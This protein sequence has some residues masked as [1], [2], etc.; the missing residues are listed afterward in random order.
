MVLAK[1][2]LKTLVKGINTAKLVKTIIK[3]NN[4]PITRYYLK[5][6]RDEGLTKASLLLKVGNAR[7][8]RDLY[9]LGV[10]YEA[11]IYHA[12]P[13]LADLSL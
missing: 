12:K 6:P 8:T 3:T 7:A 1:G 11:V 9:D 4:V 5:I 2:I 13:Y 10:I